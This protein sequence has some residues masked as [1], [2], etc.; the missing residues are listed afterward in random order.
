[1]SDNNSTNP[2]KGLQSYGPGD[3]S[4]LFG[5]ERDLI[6]MKDR[7][8]SAR[9]T[10][11]FAGSG[12]GKTSFLNAKVIPELQGQYS[13]F[14]HSRWAGPSKPLEA[15]KTTLAEQIEN[16]DK[17]DRLIDCFEEFVYKP[18]PDEVIAADNGDGNTAHKQCLLIFDQFEEIFQYHAYEDYF[19]RFLTDV[20]EVVRRDDYRVHLVISMRE[21]YLGELSVFD[22]LIPDL[23]NNYYRLRYPNKRDAAQ[24]IE[25]T[26][27]TV[28]TTVHRQNLDELISDLSKIEKG[29]ASAAE[30]S[31]QG[32]KAVGHIVERNF[33]I[34]PYLQIVCH[35]K[36]DEQARHATNNGND[37]IVFLE[38]YEPN[39]AQAMLRDYCEEKLSALSFMEQNVAERSFDFLVTKQGAKMAYEF[40]SLVEH[41]RLRFFKAR[42]RGALNKLSVPETRILRKS[43]GPDGSVW[44]ELYHDIY[45]KILDTWRVSFRGAET[46][47]N[48]SLWTGGA[49]A[50]VDPHPDHVALGLQALPE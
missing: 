50:A 24:I 2:F 27:R 14:Y 28:G 16:A 29:V 13:T 44:F 22:N 5:R 9:T 8:F 6:L 4:K 26:C 43:H 3:S 40:T 1:M 21:E 20:C 41:M 42:L 23:F 32:D 17:R 39:Q 48:R 38:S 47:V 25:G 46:Q 7:I 15:V 30:R 37:S 33:I 12:V 31:T 49:G 19:K 18:A 34:P 36:W 35:R 45:G 11:L 10:L